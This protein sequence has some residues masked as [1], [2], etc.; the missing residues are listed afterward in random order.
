M[1]LTI[2]TPLLA[3]IVFSWA[4]AEDFSGPGQIRTLDVR[5]NNQDLGCL[6][7]KGKWT[8]VESLCGEFYAQ[9]V[10]SNNEFRLSSTGGGS[11]GIDG[12][13]FKCGIQ[14]GIF[15]TWGTEGPV[16]GREVVRYGAYGLM[17]GSGNSPPDAKD[18]AVE[19]HFSTGNEGGKAVWLGWKAL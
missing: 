16:S 6:T 8:T 15:G 17:E 19:I 2:F 3:C 1:H 13:T 5:E 14:S 12:V 9:R 10:G 4:L 11:C 7:S 18:E